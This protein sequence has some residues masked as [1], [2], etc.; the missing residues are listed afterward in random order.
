MNTCFL[1][2][3]V[4]SNKDEGIEVGSEKWIEQNI[5][6]LISL[7]LWPLVSCPRHTSRCN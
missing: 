4:V 3:E 5:S 6:D 2:L 7:H 1:C